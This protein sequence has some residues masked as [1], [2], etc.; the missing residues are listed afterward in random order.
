LAKGYQHHHHKHTQTHTHKHIMTVSQ[1]QQS[2]QSGGGKQGS[3]PPYDFEVGQRVVYHAIGSTMQISVG[4]IR[5]IITEHETVGSNERPVTVKAS[6]EEPRFLIENV[7]TGKATPYKRENIVRLASE[8]EGAPGTL[9]GNLQQ[10][11]IV[12]H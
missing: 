7:N 6:E 5:D 8:D 4:I 12:Q 11:P 2:S 3:Q 9:G 1:Q 10:E